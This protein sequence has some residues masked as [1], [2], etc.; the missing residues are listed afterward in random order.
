MAMLKVLKFCLMDRRRTLIKLYFHP[1]K[2]SELLD[3]LTLQES[4]IS[5]SL[6][7]LRKATYELTMMPNISLIYKLRVFPRS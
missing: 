7:N 6:E 3:F 4:D 5:L 1:A 2:I